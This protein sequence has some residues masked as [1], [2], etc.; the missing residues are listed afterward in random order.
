MINYNKTKTY[1]GA[2]FSKWFFFRKPKLKFV[3]GICLKP[4]NH[5]DWFSLSNGKP[6]HTGIVHAKCLHCKQWNDTE[7][8]DP[9]N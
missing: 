1:N 4:N 9:S 5:R 7:L 8:E 2:T 6:I 3:C